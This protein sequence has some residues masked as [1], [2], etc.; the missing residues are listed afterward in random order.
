MHLALSPPT[1][2]PSRI[3]PLDRQLVWQWFS[4]RHN[5]KS[6]IT[7]III[8]IIINWWPAPQVSDPHP[9]LMDYPAGTVP[10][11]N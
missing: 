1:P 6:I 8:I 9:D 5:N 11:Q 3:G 4:Q 2:P 7:I 10:F